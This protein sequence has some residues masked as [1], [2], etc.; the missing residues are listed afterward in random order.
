M[1]HRLLAFSAILAFAVV[2]TVPPLKALEISFSEAGLV[3]S[4]LAPGGEIVYLSVA[5]EASGYVSAVVRRQDHLKDND[6]DGVVTIDFDGPV[7]LRSIWVVVDLATGAVAPATPA[8]YPLVSG[9]S[10][11]FA[12]SVAGGTFNRLGA[13]A[14][15]AHVL[16]VR[17]GVGAWVATLTDG[18]TADEDGEGNRTIVAALSGLEPLADGPPPP[19]E[20]AA[21]DRVVEIDSDAMT[22]ALEI[23]GGAP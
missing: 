19:L 7:P 23:V 18:S 21:G 8:D 15:R 3:V 14:I 22:Y 12:R 2:L 13:N 11:G 1:K 4:A 9:L 6:N 10:G 5:R 16:V 17:P 20:L